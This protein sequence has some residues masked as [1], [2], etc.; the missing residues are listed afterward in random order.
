MAG[1]GAIRRA[2]C[3][4]AA[5]AA[6]LAL[7]AAAPAH[8]S[9]RALVLLLPTGIW[10]TA[11]VLAVLLTV[12]ATVVLRPGLFAGLFPP[13]PPRVPSPRAAAAGRVR[14]LTSLGATALLAWLLLEGVTGPRDPLRNL[15]VLVLFAGWWICLPVLQAL[16]G[17]LWRWIDPWRGLLRLLL[18]DRHPF[19]LPTWLGHWPAVVTLLLVAGYALTDIAPAD[20]ARLA[21]AVGGYW[22]FTFVMAALFGPDW[23]ERGEGVSAWLG[24]LARLSPLDWQAGRRLPRLRMPGQGL[25]DADARAGGLSLGMVA[26]VALA[27]GSFDGLDKTFWWM[28]RLGI[29][30]LEFPGRSAVIWP[31]RA[32]LLLAVAVLGAAFAATVWLGLALAGARGR[33]RALFGPLALTLVPIALGYHLAHLLTAALVNLQYLAVA[34]LGLDPARV[35]T[36]FFNQYHTVRAIWLTQAGAIVLAHMLAVLLAHAVALRHVPDHARA[37]LSQLPV[38]L[39]MVLYTLFGLWLLAAPTAL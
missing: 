36:S 4:G 21:A 28:A 32:G 34:V 7:P 23:M 10:M 29:N 30:P 27:A 25:V 6:G 13:H 35:T 1:R 9:E 22:L 12:A 24:L 33:F 11:G 31:N 3:A 2:V 38:A 20:P 26:I 5:L 17:D 15:L 19:V 16:L 18:R 37:V 14:I 39:F 8:V